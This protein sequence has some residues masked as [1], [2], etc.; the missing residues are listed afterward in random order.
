MSTKVIQTV[1]EIILFAILFVACIFI[2]NH[3]TEGL[4]KLWY[5]Y[6]ANFDSTA[7]G[8]I[9]RSELKGEF[10]PTYDIVYRYQVGEAEYISTIIDF[11]EN[12]RSV[13]S[14]KIK[15]FPPGQTVVVYFDSK[16]PQYATLDKATP[17]LFVWV[18]A[19]SIVIISIIFSVAITG[20]LSYR[21]FGDYR[22]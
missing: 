10:R 6:Y 2:A 1:S 8:Q 21:L 9:I 17:T 14:K 7:I 4:N 16:R 22:R 3:K 18:Q 5:Y 15:Q 11:S 12:N 19:T 20:Y 13:S